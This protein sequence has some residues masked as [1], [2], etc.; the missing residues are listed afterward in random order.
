MSTQTRNEYMPD[1]VSPPRDTLRELLKER[2]ISY[3]E[4]VARTDKTASV[5]CKILNDSADAPITPGIAL[6]LEQALGLPAD[7]W[8]AREH[9]YREAQARMPGEAR[10]R[11]G[12]K[13]VSQRAA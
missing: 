12:I 9:A 1:S 13:I 2:G 3:L 8:L 7:F 4:L 11:R 5:L 10:Y 6:Q